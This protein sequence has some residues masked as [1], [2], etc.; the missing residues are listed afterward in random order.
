[1]HKKIKSN[2]IGKY[3]KNQKMKERGN[4]ELIQPKILIFHINYNSDND[5]DQIVLR[6]KSRAS[7]QKSHT[8]CAT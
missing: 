8:R 6:Q 5:L 4:F 1:M 2:F 7:L 3:Y